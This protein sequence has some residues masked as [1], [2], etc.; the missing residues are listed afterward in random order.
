MGGYTSLA[1]E[2]IQRART[3][4]TTVVKALTVLEHLVQAPGPVRLSSV[5][6]DLGLQKSNV[7]RTLAT[8]IS[9]GYVTRDPNTGLYRPTLR[10]FELG[11]KVVSEHP[12]KRAAAPYIQDLHRALGETVN[13]YVLDQGQVL[14]IDKLLSPRPLRFSTQPGSRIPASTTAA[15][16]AMLA[17]D[18]NPRE[19]ITLSQP[20]VR[21]G[22]EVDPDEIIALLPEIRRRGYAEATNAWTPGLF[23]IAAPILRR[24]GT[25]AAAI[26]VSGPIERQNDKSHGEIIEALLTTSARI[27]ENAPLL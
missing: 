14:V 23:S 8:L 7:H 27:A 26:G 9:Q 6:Q 15:G 1:R 18:P 24:D 25:A 5:A 3:L 4:D 10:L 12:A 21:P 22:I 11:A 13:L 16:R 2:R 20:L 17:Y 19:T